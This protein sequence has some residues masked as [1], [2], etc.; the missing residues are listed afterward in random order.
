MSTDKQV[1]SI[2]EELKILKAELKNAILG[3]KLLS[4]FDKLDLIRANNLASVYDWTMDIEEL[5]PNVIEKYPLIKA[6][7]YYDG[8]YF[9]RGTDIYFD[10]FAQRIWERLIDLELISEEEEMIKEFIAMDFYEHY[11]KTNKIGFCYDW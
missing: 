11:L 8:W 4:Y 1:D 3:S 9:N 6:I 7:E 10:Y 2:I 5:I